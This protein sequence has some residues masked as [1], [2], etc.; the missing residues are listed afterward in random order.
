M[1]IRFISFFILILVFLILLSCGNNHQLE[2]SEQIIPVKTVPIRYQEVSIPIR[3]SGILASPAEMKL[4]FKIEGIIER[5][6]FDE[7]DKVRKG[8][9]LAL[10]KQSEILARVNQ[11]K[12]AYE[13]AQL[14]FERVKILYED[15]VATLEQMQ[16][17]ETGLIR[18]K[19]NLEIANFN[20]EYSKILAPSDGKILKRLAE[21]NELLQQGMP[22]FIF[23]S[24]SDEWIIRT[25]VIDRDIVRLQVGDS[26][27]VTFD[28]YPGVIFTAHVSE[29]AES[30]VPMTGTYEV[31]LIL[32]QRQEKLVS[33]FVGKIDIYP[34]RKEKYYLVPIEALVEAEGKRG[35]IY[36]PK[37]P[38]DTAERIL[39]DIAKILEDQVA[40]S[41]DL[42][43]TDHV[44]TEG[45][46]YLIDG[47]KIK[48]IH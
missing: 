8:Q 5:I 36:I 18:A 45:A 30:A 10:L 16:D 42:N 48:V 46:S 41:S 13:N 29:V 22:I 1:T 37:R 19:S 34:S 39:V 32:R 38:D 23:G 47:M 21:E 44:I 26:A 28:A 3:T 43:H 33:G 35:V 40:I 11:A 7:G 14:D 17:V 25:A 20:L 27:T 15:S 12:S 6:Y 31:E 2:I 9:I 24:S 4:S